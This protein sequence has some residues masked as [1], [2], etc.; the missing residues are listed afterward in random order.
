[1]MKRLVVVLVLIAL[2]TARSYGYIS[3]IAI[4]TDNSSNMSVY[5]NG[6]LYNKQ[7]GKFVRI[8]S[9]PGLFHVR[10]K[11]LNPH[12][13]R[14]YIIRKDITVEKGF[15]MYYKIVFEKGKAPQIVASKKYPVYSK[16]FLN[17]NL[18]N[19]HPIS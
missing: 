5:V 13:K 10:V 18:Y 9:M 17:P 2:G 16:Y 8:K 6:K 1:M 3:G 11:V 14:W 15:E 12:D 7:P 19:R 4:Q